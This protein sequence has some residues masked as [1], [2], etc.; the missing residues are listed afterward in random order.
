M[1]LIATPD[2][3]YMLD[4]MGDHWTAHCA[5]AAGV[6]RLPGLWKPTQLV[7]SHLC[8]TTKRHKQQGRRSLCASLPVKE[9]EQPLMDD[10]PGCDRERR[11]HCLMVVCCCNWCS[12]NRKD[13]A[14]PAYAAMGELFSQVSI[15]GFSHCFAEPACRP[16]CLVSKFL[17]KLWPCCGLHC[18]WQAFCLRIPEGLQESEL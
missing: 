8:A 12:H 3:G 17:Q 14:R 18:R 5:W 16:A 7:S 10:L 1:L 6:Q 9:S 2:A 13:Q 15:K 11:C 4:N